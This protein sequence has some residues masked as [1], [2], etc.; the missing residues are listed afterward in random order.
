MDKEN[1]FL[2][3]TLVITNINQFKKI[4]SI[5]CNSINKDPRQ[6]KQKIFQG[7]QVGKYQIQ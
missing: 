5:K 6:N 1:P 2:C 4:Y 7:E 3:V